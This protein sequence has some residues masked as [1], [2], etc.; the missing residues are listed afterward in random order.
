VSDQPKI[1]ENLSLTHRPLV[2]PRWWVFA[3]VVSFVVFFSTL[4]F[5]GG[6][7]LAKVGGGSVGGLTSGDGGSGNKGGN[8][9][10]GSDSGNK[11]GGGGGPAGRLTSGDDGGRADFAK[12]HAQQQQPAGG[13]GGHSAKGI[14]DLGGGDG[15]TNNITSDNGNLSKNYVSGDTASPVR[16]VANNDAG[17]SLEGAPSLIEKNTE[18]VLESVGNP[19]DTAGP[20][21]GEPT[22]AVKPVAQSA[23]PLTQQASPLI[24]PLKEATDPV[25]AP[26]QHRVAPISEAARPILAPAS[27]ALEPVVGPLQ[28]AV[29]PVVE[30]VSEFAGPPV[31]GS[32]L[33]GASNS[34]VLEPLAQPLEPV[35]SAP[36]AVAPMAGAAE[37]ALESVP[38][39]GDVPLLGGTQPSLS[40]SPLIEGLASQPALA[41]ETPTAASI[42]MLDPAAVRA[43]QE[44]GNLQSS[45]SG[46]T[47]NLLSSHLKRQLSLSFFESL[48]S[49][50]LLTRIEG[51]QSQ[52]PQPSPAGETPAA[53]GGFSGGSSSSSSGSGLETAILGLLAILL[54]GGKFSW[55]ARDFLKPNATLLLAI[56]RPG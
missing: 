10:K 20:I 33:G 5:L 36:V 4:L 41:T 25:V 1:L 53:A 43:A 51:T 56:E 31:L 3:F 47:A 2:V 21:I 55:S 11:G 38:A 23:E 32:P 7:A 15:P 19:S 22:K 29:A 8:S 37:P 9:G 46:A 48:A 12:G 17:P 34:P 27:E 50:D 52:M 26:I 18:P 28:D 16:D 14:D 30:P 54:L 40:S 35:V 44:E 13:G 49:F 24:K 39:E 45:T 6:E 42:S